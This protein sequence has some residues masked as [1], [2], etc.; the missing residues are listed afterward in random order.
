MEFFRFNRSSKQNENQIGFIASI[1]HADVIVSFN[2]IVDQ[3]KYSLN[4]ELTI[5]QLSRN[6]LTKL[7]QNEWR[8]EPCLIKTLKLANELNKLSNG[9]FFDNLFYDEE[10]GQ[11]VIIEPSQSNQEYFLMN[12]F[13]TIYGFMINV[14][15]TEAQNIYDILKNIQ[16]EPSN[17]KLN[18]I[19]E[20][21]LMAYQK[22]EYL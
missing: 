6:N 22:T 8:I 1:N 11:K 12:D 3:N 2:K 17:K 13:S 4:F 16:I 10:C 15:E 14:E 18:L 9:E 21:I 20:I 7:N 5:N 19:K